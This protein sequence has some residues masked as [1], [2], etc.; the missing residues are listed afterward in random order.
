VD[1]V[2]A[3]PLTI[4]HNTHVSYSLFIP[5]LSDNIFHKPYVRHSYFHF[6]LVQVNYLMLGEKLK[7]QDE[8]YAGDWWP[9]RIPDSFAAHGVL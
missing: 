4:G 7:G 6:S 8:L 2:P 1:W 3:S 5:R 9:P